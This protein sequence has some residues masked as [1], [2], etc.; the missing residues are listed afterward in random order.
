MED[1]LQELSQQVDNPDNYIEGAI[2]ENVIEEQT[3]FDPANN[4][5]SMST[6]NAKD[7][8]SMA[9]G[10]IAAL[11]K[12]K[13]TFKDIAAENMK[14]LRVFRS[15]EDYFCL[16]IGYYGDLGTIKSV[17]SSIKRRKVILKIQE[18]DEHIIDDP[19]NDILFFDNDKPRIMLNKLALLYDL[20][21]LELDGNFEDLAENSNYDFSVFSKSSLRHL[22]IKNNDNITT[23][24]GIEKIPNLQYVELVNC[25][26]IVH[27][28]KFI[29]SNIICR[30]NNCNSVID[31]KDSI[32][33]EDKLII[34]S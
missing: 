32:K 22:I 3:E 28:Y 1:P 2:P 30:V 18:T 5:V 9:T 10:G 19:Y 31:D 24:E 12:K 33:T 16:P 34:Y 11:F 25:P 29:N 27:V 23:M 4:K 15:L 21:Y 13:N 8:V 26:N 20:L 6:D 17:Y 7:I 14:M